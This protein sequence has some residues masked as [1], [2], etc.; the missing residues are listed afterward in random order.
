MPR[1]INTGNALGAK[2]IFEF[3]A[4]ENTLPWT[5][6]AGGITVNSL[7]GAGITLTS[8]GPAAGELVVASSQAFLATLASIPAYPFTMVAFWRDSLNVGGVKDIMSITLD[9]S[10]YYQL[11]I[12]SS[13]FSLRG[14]ARNGGSQRTSSW[15]YGGGLN[16][17][18]CSAVVFASA[19]VMRTWHNGTM[20]ADT[21]T[22]AITPSGASKKLGIG[23]LDRTTRGEFLNGYVKYAAI[24]NDALTDAELDSYYANPEQIYAVPSVLSGG[25]TLDNLVA[26]GALD[27]TPSSLTGSITLDNLVASGALGQAPGTITSGVFKNWGGGV[28]AGATIPKVAVLKV[29][30][31]STVLT[32]TN[33]VTNGSGVLTLTNVAIVPGT[34]YL[35]VS[36]NAD[37]TAFGCEP[38]TAT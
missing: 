33:Q 6:A 8:P 20:S 9:D 2:C 32:L 34:Q 37:G 25:I 24:F 30:D 16:V 3:A 28:A 15:G 11:L 5:D 14:Q 26:S 18:S 36:C 27:S 12:D 35:L 22:T 31:M 1:T 21:T 13:D 17:W 7:N 10:N 19:T 4:Q 29:S 23:V 38:Y